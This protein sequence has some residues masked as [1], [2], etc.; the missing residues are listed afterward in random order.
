MSLFSSNLFAAD[1]AQKAAAAQPSFV[2]NMIPFL[3]IFAVMYFIVIRPQAKKAKDHES[4]MT[5]LK[6]GD[7]VVTSGGIIGR[8]KSITDSF[9]A[10]DTGSAVLKVT[11]G[12]VS[13][14]TQP[15][16]KAAPSKKA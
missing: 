4:L 7:E 16:A 3:L 9:I 15:G 11:K 2:E 13:G 12:H 1:E 6:P 8:V 14:K 5:G 10:I